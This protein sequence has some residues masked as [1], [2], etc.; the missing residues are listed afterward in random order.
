MNFK[1]IHK[2][3][4]VKLTNIFN[5]WIKIKIDLHYN[6]TNETQKNQHQF[7][8]IIIFIFPVDTKL[9]S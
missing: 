8:L 5:V 3:I 6:K 9:L 1:F 7:K 4:I 2:I